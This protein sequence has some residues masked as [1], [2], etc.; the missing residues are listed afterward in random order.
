M[1][2]LNGSDIMLD[3]SDYNGNTPVRI[4]LIC[5]YNDILESPKNQ[6]RWY[7]HH[8]KLNNN[9]KNFRIVETNDIARNITTSTLHIENS[10]HKEHLGRYRCHYK[11]LHK[12]ITVHAMKERMSVS[13]SNR[14]IDNSDF[15]SAPGNRPEKLGSFVIYFFVL[16]KSLNFMN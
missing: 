13:S 11:G 1:T 14:L 4:S 2:S 5:Q 3:P 7:F 9:L 8:Y 16:F 12:V 15:N 6:I 10:K